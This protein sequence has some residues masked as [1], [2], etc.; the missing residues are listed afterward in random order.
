M[1]KVCVGTI[2]CPKLGLAQGMWAGVVDTGSR[3]EAIAERVNEAGNARASVLRAS[4]GPKA[5]RAWNPG[6]TMT[7]KLTGSAAV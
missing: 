6:K 2:D 4:R 5:S 3:E 7:P 1:L